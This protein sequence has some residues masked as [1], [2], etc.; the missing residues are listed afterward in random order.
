MLG[1]QLNLS[2][3]F[4][5]ADTDITG[6]RNIGP[7]VVIGVES[8]TIE[9]AAPKERFILTADWSDDVLSGPRPPDLSGRDDA[10]LPISAAASSPNKP[11][12]ASGRST[13]K[14]AGR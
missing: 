2:A 14:A 7:V 3:A 10:H 1:G 12:V 8:N 13:S 9:G 5:Y 6:V 11:M 4:S